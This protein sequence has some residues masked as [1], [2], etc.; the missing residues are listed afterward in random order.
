MTYRNVA[1]IHILYNAST[2]RVCLDA[3]HAVEVRTVHRT[4]LYKHVAA[5]A[6]ILGTKHHTAMTILHVAV[7]D[8]DVLAWTTGILTLA[9][10]ASVF[11]SSA[12]DGYTVVAGIEDTVFDKHILA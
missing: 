4:V 11:V 9:A 1:E 6:R 7:A 2:A 10:L 3:E 5:S 12:L 8:D